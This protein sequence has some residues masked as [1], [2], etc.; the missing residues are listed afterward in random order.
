MEQIAHRRKLAIFGAELAHTVYFLLCY[1]LQDT[2]ALFFGSQ[3][4]STGTRR[5][6]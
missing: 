3:S 2:F 6:L 4:V 1:S 5:R